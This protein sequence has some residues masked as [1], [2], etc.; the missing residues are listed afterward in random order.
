MRY[1]MISAALL[2]LF[3]SHAF[4]YKNAESKLYPSPDMYR[5]NVNDVVV[6][7][8]GTSRSMLTVLSELPATISSVGGT[9]DGSSLID[10]F[11][12]A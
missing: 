11:W 9:C 5:P 12:T 6:N 10:T 8:S 7:G 1:R 4:A 3:S 2:A